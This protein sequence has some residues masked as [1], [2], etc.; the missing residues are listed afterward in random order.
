MSDLGPSATGFLPFAPVK[1]VVELLL[2]SRAL[3]ELSLMLRIS[4]DL[5]GLIFLLAPLAS[6]AVSGLIDVINVLL[7]FEILLIALTLLFASSS[8]ELAVESTRRKDFTIG[9]SAAAVA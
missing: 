6:S 4:L 2:T 1:L 8:V 3:T 5:L 9:P 7:L